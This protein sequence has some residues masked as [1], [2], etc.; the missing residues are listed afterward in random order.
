MLNPEYL[1]GQSHQFQGWYTMR[2]LQVAA[3]M[4]NKKQLSY[5]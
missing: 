4:A 5:N 3:V 2:I 1:G